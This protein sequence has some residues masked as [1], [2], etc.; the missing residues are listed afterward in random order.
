MDFVFHN[1]GLLHLEM[2]Y[3]KHVKHLSAT[4]EGVKEK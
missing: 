1:T 4:I 3:I 2:T